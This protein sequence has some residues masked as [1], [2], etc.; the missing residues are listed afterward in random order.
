[1]AQPQDPI[2]TLVIWEP[3]YVE[4]NSTLRTLAN[5]LVAEQVGALLV[6]EP[7]SGLSIVAERDVVEALADGADPDE[8]WAADVSTRAVRVARPSDSI[9]QVGLEMLDADVRHIVLTEG[10]RVVGVVSVRDVL[11]PLVEAAQTM[12]AANG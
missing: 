8:V 10:D 6:D 12:L 7:G 9:A 2:S 5:R 4:P 1:M 11:R 3:L